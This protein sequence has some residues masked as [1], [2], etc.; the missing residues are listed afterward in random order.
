MLDLR[1]KTSIL[2]KARELI[3]KS[4]KSIDE[5]GILASG[6]GAIGNLIQENWFGIAVNN[7]PEP[8]FPE[9]NLELKVTPFILRFNKKRAKERLVCN[10]IDYFSE[11]K[12]TFLSSSF[13][14][15]CENMLILT[16]HHDKALKKS[17]YVIDEAF[18][19]KFPEM[20]LAIIRKDWEDIV[21]KIKQGRAHEISEGD[22][23]YLGACTK[24]SSSKVTRK[25][26]F[27]DI[28]AKP[29]AFSLKQSYVNHVLSSYVYGA[30]F[31]PYVIRDFKD[32]I[33]YV[34]YEKTEHIIRDLSLFSSYGF[35]GYIKRLTQPHI[36]KSITQLKSEFSINS[37]AKHVQYLLFARMLGLH[38][39]ISDSDEFKK[40]GIIPKTIHLSKNGNIRESM[41]FPSSLFAPFDIIKQKWEDSALFDFFETNK[42]LFIVFR[43][44]NG[45]SIFENVVLWNM[46][47]ADLEEVR[48]VWENTKDVLKAG[49]KT[50]QVG[51]RTLNNLPKANENRVAH[52]RPHARNKKDVMKLPGGIL[53]T[54]QSFWLNSNY[55]KEQIQKANR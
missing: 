36:G 21:R 22:T 10:M 6:K 29:R 34:D 19:Y 40:A 41:S 50:W 55:I 16:Y 53:L 45:E 14:K 35:Q 15:K 38:G 52:V 12:Q 46:P 20:D 48:I 7:T 11:H 4:L 54:K 32:S 47:Q 37:K 26:P 1:S 27:S 49:V 3:G 13:W 18:I 2:S 42:F 43:R 31:S 30:A 24:A 28:P 51:N 9:A 39:S 33:Q 44:I 23:L 17:E 5:K 25:Q 8:D